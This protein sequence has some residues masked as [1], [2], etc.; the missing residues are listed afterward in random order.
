MSQIQSFFISSYGDSSQ[1]E[2]LNHFLRS[3]K[4]IR[5][6]QGFVSGGENPGFQI[7][8]E[9]AEN[10][11]PESSSKKRIDYRSMLKEEKQIVIFD[12]LKAFRSELCKKEKLIGAYMI[13]KDEHLYQMAL[14]PDITVD[15]IKSFPH[16][17]NIKLE[18]YGSLLY[19]Q[20][21]KIKSNEEE[22]VPF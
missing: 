1:C 19:E 16:S 11:S 3:H 20:L 4:I 5:L 9:Y 21:Q 6:S 17:A 12:A 7:I 13:C 22:T 15:E 14:N 10:K 2:E 18:E 8:V